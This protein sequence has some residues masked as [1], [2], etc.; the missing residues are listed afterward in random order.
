MLMRIL[1]VDDDEVLLDVAKEFLEFSGSM[2]VDIA[3]SVSDARQAMVEKEY[4]AIISDY[5]MPIE[6]G[7]DFLKKLRAENDHIPFILF[8]GRGRE[9]VVIEALNSGANFYIQKGG[10]PRAQFAELQ[11]KVTEAVKQK[12]AEE[13]L[14]TKSAQLKAAIDMARL[15]YFHLDLNT[16]MYTV[17]DHLWKMLGTD[18]KRENGYQMHLFTYL[19]DIVHPDDAPAMVAQMS[20][21]LDQGSGLDSTIL[22]FRA[23]RRDG[24]VR[25]V[26][27]YLHVQRAPDGKA[28]AV[29]GAIQDVTEA[30]NAE[31]KLEESERKYRLLAENITDVIWM[32]D[33][34]TQKFLY[35]SPSITKLRGLTVEEAMVETLADSVTPA[36]YQTIMAMMQDSLI[37]AMKGEW[38]PGSH[39]SGQF[40]QKH[41]DGHWVDVEVSTTFVK[42]DKGEVAAVL[43]VS[44]DVSARVMADEALKKKTEDIERFFDLSL[45]LLCIAGQDGRFLQLN[46]AWEDDLGYPLGELI[47]LDFLS[48]VHPDDVASSLEAMKRLNDQKEVINFVNRY[49]RKDGTYRW[50]EWRSRPYGDVIYAA[51]RDITERKQILD[52]ISESEERSRLIL[53]SAAE[54]IYGIDME[55]KCTFSNNSCLRMLGYASDKELLGKNMHFVMHHSH[56]NGLPYP[57]EDCPIFNAFRK[58]ERTH[59]TNE[60]L[61]RSDGT[62]FPAELWSYPQ[63]KDGKVIGAV[64]TFIDV[65]ERRD[66]ENELQESERRYRTVTENSKEG[67]LV[68][69]NGVIRYANPK[70]E[71]V[72]QVRAPELVGRNFIDFVL[73][74]DRERVINTYRQ[75]L[76]GETVPERYDLRAQGLDGTVT[77]LSASAISI[78]WDGQPATLN[79]LMDITERKD[80]E[81]MLKRSEELLNLAIEG[82]Q[83]GL[84]D[85]QV[86]TGE[87]VINERWANMVGYT[88][89]ELAPVSFR[90][91]QDLVHPDDMKMAERLLQEHF[92]GKSE[93]FEFI[94]RSRHKDGHWVWIMGRGK[95]SF[96]SAEGKPL[97]MIGTHIDITDQ[98]RM[99]ESLQQ[100]GKKL[101]IL[102]SITRHDVLNQVLAISGNAA[103]LERKGLTPEQ[104]KLVLRMNRSAET[105]Q[106]QM[107]FTRAYQEIGL[108]APT[109]QS[110]REKVKLAKAALP[111]GDLEVVEESTDYSIRADPMFEKV[112]YNMI[113]NCLRHSGGARHLTVSADG[114]AG[115]LSIV[116]EDDG[117]GISAEDKQHLFERGYGK[118]TGFGL[119]LSRE[120]LSITDITIEENSQGG[121]GARF[122]I[123][124]PAGDWRLS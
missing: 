32:L 115:F 44:R 100:A 72:A 124:V 92:Q 27:T 39:V 82:S 21:V 41:K 37:K 61:W 122:Q 81:T 7:I 102:N 25:D 8:T 49:R 69:Q 68:V 58:G 118:N 29:N 23:I 86:Q 88:L 53:A 85:W 80:S 79:F 75:R 76:R 95:V 40:K 103:I 73:P 111:L 67:I 51:A 33:I 15:A 110:L 114:G 59:L 5:Q 84:W 87:L 30:R 113:D 94:G 34:A 52:H 17:D 1:Y 54:G 108:H 26:V 35:I 62:Q 90:T 105:I 78:D 117:Q 97:R 6:N 45:D 112:I 83:V 56:E 36:D 24:E 77:W 48:L 93:H 10:D 43:G 107:E 18:S 12:K 96:W 28:V 9:E 16:N 22:R 55:G 47:G 46:K 63:K 2:Q 38:L 91:W 101:A 42:N 109:W 71:Q 123:K 116:F 98:K 11:H 106:R 65:T 119:F 50:I 99:E 20:Q 14:I 89:E 57:V 4:D 13:E 60:F 64:V 120:I 3:L 74:E 104:E 70:V 66:A 19:R 31:R 121:K